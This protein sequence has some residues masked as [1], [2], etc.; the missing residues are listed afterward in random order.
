[1]D[2]VRNPAGEPPRQRDGGHRAQSSGTGLNFSQWR[3]RACIL[4]SLRHLTAGMPVTRIAALLGY[5]NPAAYTAAF[6]KL[7]G[8]PPTAHKPQLSS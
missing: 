7:L 6:K 8:R 4:H 1:M 2:A 3:Q 5:E